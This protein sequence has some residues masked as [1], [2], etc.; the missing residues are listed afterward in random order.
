MSVCRSAIARTVRHARRPDRVSHGLT[1]VSGATL[2]LVLLFSVYAAER[3]PVFPDDPR[4][5]API[6]NYAHYSFADLLSAAGR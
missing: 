6:S 3:P 1:W 2:L 4:N 5:H